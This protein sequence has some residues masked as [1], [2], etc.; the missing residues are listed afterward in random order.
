MPVHV[1]DCVYR[2]ASGTI[3]VR[4]VL[5][6]GLEDRFQHKLGGGLNHPIPDRWNAERS[7]ASI[8]FRD[9]HPPHR[10]GPVHLRDQFLTQ[11]HQPCLQ[12]LL[13]AHAQDRPKIEVVPSIPHSGQVLS[14]AFSYDGTRVLSGSVGEAKLWDAASGQL[15]RTFQV[16]SEVRSVALSPDG[17]RVLMGAEFHSRDSGLR[18][19]NVASGQ[20]VRTF[21]TFEPSRPIAFSPDGI[22]VLSRGIYDRDGLKLWNVASGRLLHELPSVD[23]PVVF[24]PNGRRILTSHRADSYPVFDT[25]I[26]L[27]DVASGQLIL[28]IAAHSRRVLSV[29]FSPD[30]NRLLSG[31]EDST[32]WDAVSGKLIH[33]FDGSSKWIESIAFSPDG[34]RILSGGGGKLLRL[35][36]AASGQAIRTFEAQSP[37]QRAAFSPDGAHVLATS[38]EKVSLLDAASGQLIRMIEGATFSPDGTRVISGRLFSCSGIY[39]IRLMLWD[40]TSAQLIL[41]LEGSAEG[42][43]GAVFSPDGTRLLWRVNK[44]WNSGRP[45]VVS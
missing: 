10:I 24:S 41:S 43:S 35:W 26:K 28:T 45:R 13:H 2:P 25:V 11:A 16:S 38:G 23:G 7:L 32:L 18:L 8:R 39:F 36:D 9:H 29:A 14:V 20:V 6:V 27:W 1:L 30:G 37:V 12:T 44:T 19:W 17:T 42:T 31:S 33:S 22:Y 3:A 21:E 4:I 34:T 15:I 5:E 40:A